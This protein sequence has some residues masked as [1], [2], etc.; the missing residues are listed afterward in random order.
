MQVNNLLPAKSSRQSSA[1]VTTLSASHD[2]L[3]QQIWEK[4]RLECDVS[5]QLGEK[6]IPH[7]SWQGAD[8]YDL[9]AVYEVLTELCESE[10]PFKIQTSGV[11]IFTGQF[12]TFYITLVRSQPL[13]ILHQKI[14]ERVAALGINLNLYYSPQMWIP[15]ITVAH[16]LH[17]IEEIVCVT[18]KLANQFFNWQI[19]VDHLTMLHIGPNSLL[20]QGEH[21][22]FNG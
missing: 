16:N 19:N 12:V 11:G 18:G 10:R 14:W 4:M 5:L 9:P 8:A 21:F 3:V 2:E 17:A 20:Q 15:H 13:S 22:T 7:F 6:P 1:I